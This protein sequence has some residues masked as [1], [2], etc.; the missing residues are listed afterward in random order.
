MQKIKNLSPTKLFS[1]KPE[2][3]NSPK[4]SKDKKSPVKSDMQTL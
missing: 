3:E 1:K 2:K 4:K